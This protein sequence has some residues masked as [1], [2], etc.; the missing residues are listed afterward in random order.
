MERLTLRLPIAH[1]TCSYFLAVPL[2]PSHLT[3]DPIL[4]V[5]IGSNFNISY[6][7]RDKKS[8]CSIGEECA[9]QESTLEIRHLAQLLFGML[10][11]I[12]SII[13]TSLTRCDLNYNV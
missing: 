4:F 8:L 1:S 12:H 2:Q 6:E 10:A 9:Q 5:L 13:L 11:I 7:Q 3:I